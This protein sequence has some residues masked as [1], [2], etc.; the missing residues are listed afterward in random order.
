MT[1]RG[2]AQVT[3]TLAVAP[4]TTYG[5]CRTPT[6]ANRRQRTCT[7]YKAVSGSLTVAGTPGTNR[8]TFRG[9]IGA[10]SLRPGSYRLIATAADPAGNVS[11]PSSRTFRIA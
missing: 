3:T 5:V 4:G 2:G 6:H 8:F 1:G 9:R 10:T 11:L 7:L